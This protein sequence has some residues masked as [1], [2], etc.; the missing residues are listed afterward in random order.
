MD[1]KTNTT[2]I[3]PEVQEEF[4]AVLEHLR[5]GKP[6]PPEMDRR[7][8]E[9]AEKIREEVFKKHGLVDIAVPSIRELR[10]DLPEP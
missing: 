2:G 3:P 1:T 5:T 4:E 9:R 6:L 10:G 8:R 7:I